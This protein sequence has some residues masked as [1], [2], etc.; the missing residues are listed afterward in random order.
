MSRQISLLGLLTSVRR[1]G[2]WGA[3]RARSETDAGPGS[4]QAKPG[5]ARVKGRAQCCALFQ[6]T[7][8]RRGAI[9]TRRSSSCR[10]STRS[11]PNTPHLIMLVSPP[12]R[13]TATAHIPAVLQ[14]RTTNPGQDSHPFPPAHSILQIGTSQRSSMCSHVARISVAPRSCFGLC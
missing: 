13:H 6:G 4:S 1:K 3:G 14:Q 5:Q 8:A 12:V 9:S 11:T 10:P 7:S 2:P